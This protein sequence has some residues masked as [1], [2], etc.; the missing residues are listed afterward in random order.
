MVVDTSNELGGDGD[1][2]HPSLQYA[3]RMQV[4][5]ST[6]LGFLRLLPQCKSRSDRKKPNMSSQIMARP[7]QS[8]FCTALL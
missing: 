5:F 8:P 1:V 7:Y 4:N 3:R 2:P 6:R